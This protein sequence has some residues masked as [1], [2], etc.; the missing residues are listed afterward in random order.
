MEIKVELVGARVVAF[1]KLHAIEVVLLR[2][3]KHEAMSPLRP[4]QYNISPKLSQA[5][6]HP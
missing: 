1:I 6:L 2:K 3:A 4:N 5:C